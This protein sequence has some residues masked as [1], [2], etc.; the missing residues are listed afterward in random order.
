MEA[1]NIFYKNDKFAYPW[2][3]FSIVALFFSPGSDHNCLPYFCS[4]EN[5]PCEIKVLLSIDNY[6]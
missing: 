5:Q 6:N 3:V 4:A 1:D 2:Y